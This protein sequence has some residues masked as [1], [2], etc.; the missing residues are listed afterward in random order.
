MSD[1]DWVLDQNVVFQMDRS[2]F[3]HKIFGGR[4]DLFFGDDFSVP[5]EDGVRWGGSCQ[6]QSQMRG[7]LEKL[8]AE[9]KNTPIA[10]LEQILVF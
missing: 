7:N 5:V 4:R 10:K 9:A 6:R 8:S 1:W 2:G 3:F